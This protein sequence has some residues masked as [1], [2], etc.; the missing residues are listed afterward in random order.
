MNEL[1]S[2]ELVHR[3]VG[4]LDSDRTVGENS[5]VLGGQKPIFQIE[6][7]IDELLKIVKYS[8]LLRYCDKIQGFWSSIEKR[9]VA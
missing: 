6:I 5:F 7:K 2:D 3:S 9:R 1:S 4:V 8:N